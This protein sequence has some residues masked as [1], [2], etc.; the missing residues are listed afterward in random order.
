[1]RDSS[2]GRMPARERWTRQKGW[3]ELKAYA[4]SRGSTFLA[5]GAIIAG[6]VWLSKSLALTPIW[7]F[8]V[9]SAGL[10]LGSVAV[11]R[12]D[13][14]EPSMLMRWFARGVVGVLALSD[15]AYLIL[16]VHGVFVK[17]ALDPLGLLLAGMV[18][19]SVNIAVFALAF[20]EIDGGGPEDRA[21]DAAR[22]PDLVFPQQQADQEKLAPLDWKP[23]FSDYLYV[24]VTASTAFSPTDAMPYSRSAKLIM[25]LEST[26]SFAIVVMLVARAVNI[27]KG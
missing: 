9:L 20:W 2:N 16:L 18:L 7:L 21:R 15:A 12:S 5:A 19:W 13:R 22:L 25:A 26:I 1:M 6:Q 4:E 3:S 17:S 23:S 24:S 14:E 11:Y 8:P 27:A 10:L